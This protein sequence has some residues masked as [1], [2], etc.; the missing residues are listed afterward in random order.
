[1][2]GRHYSSLNA[3]SHFSKFCRDK[4]NITQVSSSF[5][6]ILILA[7]MI[8]EEALEDV[9]VDACPSEERGFFSKDDVWPRL[10]IRISRVVLADGIKV[11]GSNASS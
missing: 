6:P 5:R 2:W 9:D 8:G 3:N 10:F 1:M 11:G 7:P 4:D